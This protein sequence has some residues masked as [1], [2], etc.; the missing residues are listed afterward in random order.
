MRCQWGSNWDNLQPWISARRY[1]EFD[2]LDA[3]VR[4]N[5]NA[6]LPVICFMSVV[7]SFA[8]V[9]RRW[10]QKYPSYLRKISFIS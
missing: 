10:P 9:F 4:Y 3:E 1:R 5:H 8:N 6:V 2:R 7:N